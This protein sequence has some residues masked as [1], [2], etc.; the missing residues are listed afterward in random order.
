VIK[1]LLL[2]YDIRWRKGMHIDPRHMSLIVPK[3]KYVLVY[4]DNGVI[5]RHDD[6]SVHHEGVK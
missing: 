2:G 1:R 5:V 3:K 4:L 6:K